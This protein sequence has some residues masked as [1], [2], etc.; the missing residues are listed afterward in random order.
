VS[1]FTAMLIVIL[2]LVVIPIIYWIGLGLSRLV[3]HRGRGA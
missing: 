2:V 1:I 3:R